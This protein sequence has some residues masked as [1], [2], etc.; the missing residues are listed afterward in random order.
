M[1]YILEGATTYKSATT[2]A[3]WNGLYILM[4]PLQ[5]FAGLALHLQSKRYSMWW[6]KS[7]MALHVGTMCRCIEMKTCRFDLKILKTWTKQ[8]VNVHIEFWEKN[9]S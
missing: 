6:L 3:K 7:F 9:P 8:L 5:S 1:N 4:L 2:I